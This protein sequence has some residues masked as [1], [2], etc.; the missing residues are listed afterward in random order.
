MATVAS[1]S[2][3]W[4]P[5]HLRAPPPK[6]MKP[7]SLATS[8]GYRLLPCAS[9]LYPAHAPPKSGLALRSLKRSGRN[10]SG[11]LHRCG[12]LRTQHTQQR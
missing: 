9:G 3:N 2:A 1:S 4:S 12:D 11:S 6:G 10:S 7:K 5:T 8:L